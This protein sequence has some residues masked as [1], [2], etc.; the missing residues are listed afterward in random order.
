MSRSISRNTSRSTSNSTRREG[1]TDPQAEGVNGH[2]G[3]STNGYPTHE[4]KRQRRVSPIPAEDEP[5][6]GF[7]FGFQPEDTAAEREA[8]DNYNRQQGTRPGTSRIP[9]KK[10]SP[11]PPPSQVKDERKP[12][13]SG[14]WGDLNNGGAYK[15]RARS[16]SVGSAVLL[17]DGDDLETP[18]GGG[19][20]SDSASQQSPPKP[21]V[22]SK[23]AGAKKTPRAASGSKGGRKP[24]G[25]TSPSKRPGT[26]SGTPRPSTSHRPEGDPPWI[27]NMYK[28]D[29]RLPPDQQILPTHAK[30][31][32]QEQWERE[33]KT[34]SVYDREFRLLNTEEFMRGETKTP[35]PIPP[36]PSPKDEKFEDRKPQ[37]PLPSPK[38]ESFSNRPDTSHSNHGG[39]STIP[40]IRTPPAPLS[41]RSPVGSIPPRRKSPQPQQPI[42]LQEPPEDEKTK[43]GCGCCAVM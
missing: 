11:V 37:W 7:D 33:G 40:T 31:M 13:G 2:E 36:E 14:S 21:K 15:H 43:K 6:E 42:R 39:Y 4:E 35:S 28:P 41:P 22:P 9:V 20:L 38:A 3:T 26:S 30:R 27:A 1:S 16:G 24:S 5:D 34:G 8:Q 32:A 29:P 23:S 25:T 18:S 12:A 19:S 10:L 17:D